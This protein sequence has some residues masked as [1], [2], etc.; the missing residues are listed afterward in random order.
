MV[1]DP[2]VEG[3]YKL[4]QVPLGKDKTVPAIA[5]KQAPKTEINIDNKP[6]TP[7]NA[8]AI[9]SLI[10]SVDD[11]GNI[12]GSV[13]TSDGKVNKGLLF[14][15][16]INLP[17]SNGRTLQ[18]WV[19]EVMALTI[20]AISG[21]QVPDEERTRLGK[22]YAPSQGDSPTTVRNKMQSLMDTSMMA[23][24]VADPKGRLQ[25]IARG[26]PTLDPNVRKNQ[27]R[28]K[29]NIHGKLLSDQE[30]VQ[31]MRAEGYTDEQFRQIR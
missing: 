19:G 26:A 14:E 8:R 2:T 22:V 12:L 10:K 28:K 27:L 30:I 17:F 20:Q 3:G 25:D 24:K 29:K 9:A 18:T 21:V 13:I 23:L 31:R 7:S 11:V 4:L 6:Q 15:Q 1:E 16:F 5:Q